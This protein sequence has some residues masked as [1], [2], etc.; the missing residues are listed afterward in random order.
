[1]LERDVP[2]SIAVLV[3]SDP[4]SFVQFLATETAKLADLSA[5]PT[6]VIHTLTSLAS[7]P[8]YAVSDIDFYVRSLYQ[9]GSASAFSIL[10]TEIPKGV[11][12]AAI[13][14]PVGFLASMV[15]A[16]TNPSWVSVLHSSLQGLVASAINHALNIVASDVSVPARANAPENVTAAAATTTASSALVSASAVVKP[17][18]SIVGA[19]LATRS[20]VVFNG[21]AASLEP[22]GIGST[23][24][25]CIFF[26]LWLAL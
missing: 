19:P 26:G 4:Q 6:G 5:V 22:T 24:L 17:G 7:E 13:A 18:S 1:M 2:A 21:D 10:A 11:Q 20:S 23:L 15:A 3:K 16:S 8:L 14:D 12:D 25:T 9:N